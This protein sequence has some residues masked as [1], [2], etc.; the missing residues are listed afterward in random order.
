MFVL[1]V[2]SLIADQIKNGT[3]ATCSS[4][5]AKRQLQK[6]LEILLITHMLHGDNITVSR[7]CSKVR[8]D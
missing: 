7:N 6:A 4:I 3:M 1:K 5:N 2:L 8:S